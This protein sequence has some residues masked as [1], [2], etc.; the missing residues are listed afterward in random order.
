MSDILTFTLAPPI[1]VGRG[2]HSRLTILAMAGLGHTADQA[3]DLLYEL[4]RAR[5]VPDSLVPGDVVGMGSTVHY[6]TFSGDERKVTLSYPAE[7]DIS[8]GRVSVL[9]PIGTALLGL[10][11][12][13]SM[14]WVTRDGKKQVLTVLSVA[15]PGGGPDSPLAA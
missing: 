9:T 4:E 10:T 1:T 8:A 7:A 12:G 15:P 14:S 2:D 13:Q 6:R 5:I 11:R 3:D